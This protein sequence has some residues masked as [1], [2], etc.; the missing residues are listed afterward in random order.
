MNEALSIKARFPPVR[1]PAVGSRHSPVQRCQWFFKQFGW[2]GERII[3]EPL[4]LLRRFVG[5][6]KDL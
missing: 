2:S 3:R 4:K 1:S 6:T 5:R